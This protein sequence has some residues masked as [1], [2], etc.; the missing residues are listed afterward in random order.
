MKVTIIGP[1]PP[2]YGGISVHVKRMKLFLESIGIDVEIYNESKL[3]EDTSNIKKIK[4]YKTFLLKVPFFKTDIIHFHSINKYVRILLAIYK[5]FGKKIVL[6]IHGE[7]LFNQLNSSELLKKIMI[8]CLNRI[9]AIIC[10]NPATKEQVISYGIKEEKVHVIPAYINPITKEED[11]INID[12]SVWDFIENSNFLI[13][14]NGWI[15]IYDGQDLYGLDM[16]INLITKLKNIGYNVSLLFALI[17]KDEQSADEINYYSKIKKQIV[18]LGLQDNIYIYETKNSEFYPILTKSHLF[19][20]PTN[21][22]GFGVSIAEAIYYNVPAI[23]SNVCKRPKGTILFENRNIN[24]LYERTIEVIK[25]NRNKDYYK[26]NT[27]DN[28]QSLY[29]LYNK[30]FEKN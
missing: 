21:T 12:K 7:S 3:G 1:Y 9:D 10:V 13:S 20:R 8:F 30:I 14:A 24:E 4:N 25:S 19:I 11:F 6:T 5:L 27:V 26:Y 16:L 22:D 29:G 15:R 17:G 18:E 2:L 28:S 23:A